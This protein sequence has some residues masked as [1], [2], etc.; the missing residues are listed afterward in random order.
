[1]RIL[2]LGATGMLGHALLARCATEFDAIGTVRG[3]AAPLRG[4][5]AFRGAHLIGNVTADRPETLETAMNITRPDVVVNCIGA[6]KQRSEGNDPATALRVNGVFPHRAAA[7]VAERGARFIHLS[8][9]CVFSGKLGRPYLES[10][11]PDATDIY[12][13]SKLVG[14]VTT[15]GA[16]TLR[17]SMIGWELGEP[18]GFLEWAASQKGKTVQGFRNALFSGLTTPALADRIAGLIRDHAGLRGLWHVAAQP[19]NKRDLLE[20]LNDKL[21]L[22]L[23]IQPADT[24]VIDRRLDAGCL[25]LETGLQPP[26]WDEMLDQLAQTPRQPRIQPGE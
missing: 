7:I 26:S 23:D 14:E 16:L 24:P 17:T 9:D 10:D 5:P 19:I 2:I 13:R 25:G 18:T 22:N 15:A 6:V 11:L 1:M 21:A 4:H 8:T 20:R 3:Y 12:G